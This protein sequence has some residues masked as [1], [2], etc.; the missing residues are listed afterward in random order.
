MSKA[1]RRAIKFWILQ[2]ILAPVALRVLWLWSRT[3]R[4]SPEDLDEGRRWA[5]SGPLIVACHHGCSLPLLAL[6]RVLKPLGKQLCVM[7]SPS[8]DG[9]LM[10]RVMEFFGIAVVKGSSKSKA[11]QAALGMVDAMKEGRIGYIA[12]D[13]PRGPLG[14][15]KPG[16]IRLAETA[17]A[18]I[19]ILTPTASSA[20]QFRKAWDRMFLPKPF[21]RIRYR[22]T[23]FTPVGD[24]HEAD[25]LRIQGAMIQE[26]RAAHSPIAPHLPEP[27][28]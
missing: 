4:L 13:G 15:V 10:D 19:M 25:R 2:R 5:T 28:R 9:Q 8:H 17:G 3:W 22:M 18:R 26:A 6:V 21:A 23:E 20:I 12:V 7:T 11:V 14:E 27:P 24:D 1:R 16:I